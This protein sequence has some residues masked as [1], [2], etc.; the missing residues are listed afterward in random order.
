[1]D[2]P[3]LSFSRWMQAY[4]TGKEADYLTRDALPEKPLEL[5]SQK[6]RMS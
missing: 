5:N 1:M 4:S 6:N 2:M 3:I